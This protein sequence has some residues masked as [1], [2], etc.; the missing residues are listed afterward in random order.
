MPLLN[1]N[2]EGEESIT[3]IYFLVADLRIYNYLKKE[4]FLFTINLF[5]HLII[6]DIL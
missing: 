6:L 3:I 1:F 4:A 5:Y 2:R